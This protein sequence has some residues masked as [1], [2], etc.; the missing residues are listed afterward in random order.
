MLVGTTWMNIAGAT[1]S[2]YRVTEANE[3]H[4]IRVAASFKDDTGQ[5]ASATSAATAAVLD[6]KPTLSVTSSGTAR[7]GQTLTAHVHETSDGDGGKTIYHW[8]M[9]VGTTWTNIAGA[10]GST[11]RVTEAN[12]GHKIRVAATFTDDTGQTVSAASAATAPAGEGATSAAQTITVTDP[13]LPSILADAQDQGG[14]LQDSGGSA[15]GEPLVNARSDAMSNLMSWGEFGCSQ[16]VST[17]DALAQRV[18]LLGQYMAS[19]FATSSAG[20]AATLVADPT[21]ATPPQSLLAPPEHSG[22]G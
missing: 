6:V 3:G 4:K 14:A 16:T 2:T 18:A 13:P 22:A 1:G 10:T 11:Y 15:A 12:E 8:Q 9:L 7:Q 21:V 17:Q 5:T 19:T 20:D